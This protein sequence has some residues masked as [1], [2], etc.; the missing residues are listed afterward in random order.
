MNACAF[1]RRV[2]VRLSRDFAVARTLLC[3]PSPQRRI[4]NVVGDLDS[5]R[6]ADWVEIDLI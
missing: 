1:K 4:E 6:T 3:S 5:D 2:E